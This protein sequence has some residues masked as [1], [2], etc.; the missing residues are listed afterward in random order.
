MFVRNNT[1][2]LHKERTPN[3]GYTATF[4]DTGSSKCA[5]GMRQPAETVGERYRSGNCDPHGG[6]PRVAFLTTDRDGP[7]EE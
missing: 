5:T 6:E 3:D 4:D 1:L 2:P 7:S